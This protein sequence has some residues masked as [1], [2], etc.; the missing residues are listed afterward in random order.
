MTEIKDIL[1][2]IKELDLESMKMAQEEL[3]SKMKPQ[4]SLGILEK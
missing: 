2:N 4:G 1:G 3:D